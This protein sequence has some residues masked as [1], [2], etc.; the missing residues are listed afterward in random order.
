MHHRLLITLDFPADADS[1]DVRI[2][3]FNQLVNDDSFCGEGGRFG[4]P[5]CDWFVI[6]GRWSGLL[7]KITIGAAFKDAVRARFP[8]LAGEWWP[9]AIADQHGAELD[10]IWQ[11]QGGNGPSPYTRSSYEHLGY[12]DDAMILTPGLY[13]ALLSEYAG[14]SRSDGHADLDDE[15]LGPDCIGRKWLTLI[16]YHN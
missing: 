9:Q 4:S 8:E 6:G 5:L 12:P 16:D 7:A 1:A 13:E 10:D 2:K 14:E 3:A 11:A 15:E